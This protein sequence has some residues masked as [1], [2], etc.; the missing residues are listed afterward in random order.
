MDIK[1]LKRKAGETATA[2]SQAHLKY[3]WYCI[4][5]AMCRD[6]EQACPLCSRDRKDRPL[7]DSRGTS[8]A[9]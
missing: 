1:K 5:G 2:R 7:W 8:K 9:R 6:N 3:A 4:C